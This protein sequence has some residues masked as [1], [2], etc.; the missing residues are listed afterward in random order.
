M[1][2]TPEKLTDILDLERLEVDL[3]RGRSPHEHQQRVFGGQVA[4]QSLVAAGRT[5]SA[6][7]AVNSLH[8][9]FLRLGDPEIPIVYSVD[10]IRDGRSFTTRRV[11]AI[12][13]GR[14]IYLLSASFHRA[15]N[16]LQHQVPMPKVPDPEVLSPWSGRSTIGPTPP[17]W[18]PRRVVELRYVSD[19]AAVGAHGGPQDSRRIVWMRA[20]HRLPDDPLVHVCAVTYASDMTLLDAVLLGHGLDWERDVSS[21]AS[22]DHAMWFHGAFR[23]D[24]WILYVQESPAA[25]DARGLAM[26]RIYRRDGRLVASVVQEGLIRVASTF[27]DGQAPP[28][29]QSSFP[30]SP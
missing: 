9:Y 3:F 18:V 21:G 28:P 12:Q 10:R 30:N 27:G 19:P 22:L 20:P 8:S 23:A 1:T 16:G 15:E 5:V 26:G 17:P 29:G 2:A 13:H 6:D 14:P 24:E 7:R 25:S 11:V 4:A